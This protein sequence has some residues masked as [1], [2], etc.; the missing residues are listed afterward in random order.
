MRKELLEKT[1]KELALRKKSE[2]TQKMY[3]HFIERFLENC[4]KEVSLLNSEDARNFISSLTNNLDASSVAIARCALKFFYKEILQKDLETIEIPKKEKKT[5]NI[6]TREE[7]LK[8]IR[9]AP[10]LREKLL[11]KFMYY[12]GLKVSECSNLKIENINLETKRITLLGSKARIVNLHTNLVED[13]KEFIANKKEGYLFEGNKN[14][15]LSTRAIQK[16]VSKLAK[17]VLNKDVNCNM[18][19]H[20]FAVH[21]LEKGVDVYTLKD[22]LSYASL[23]SAKQYEDLLKKKAK[24]ENPFKF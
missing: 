24:L 4:N 10:S 1:R 15:P 21:M 7:I 23:Q 12:C 2:H 18:L 14:N 22:M 3:L 16:I 9:N 6:L 13:L 19:R 17:Q 8:L 20:S 5:P 11:I